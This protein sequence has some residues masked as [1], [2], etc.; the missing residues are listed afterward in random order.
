MFPTISALDER[1]EHFLPKTVITC[2]RFV[3]NIPRRFGRRFG[4]LWEVFGDMFGMCLGGYLESRLKSKQPDKKSSH[5][6]QTIT[7]E[8]DAPTFVSV[9]SVLVSVYSLWSYLGTMKES[10]HAIVTG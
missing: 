1:I 8:P 7:T 10:G 3:G 5:T 2:I 6:K 9:K 4:M